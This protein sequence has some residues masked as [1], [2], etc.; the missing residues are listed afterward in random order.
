MLGMFCEMYVERRDSGRGWWG[1]M[2]VAFV[3]GILTLSYDDDDDY[4]CEVGDE[5]RCGLVGG[6][7]DSSAEVEADR[8]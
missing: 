3:V 7:G 8:G 4:D 1:L 5:G 2:R 6:E